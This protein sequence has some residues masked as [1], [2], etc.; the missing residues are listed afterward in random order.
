MANINNEQILSFDGY[1]V[2]VGELPDNSLAA[3]LALGFSTKI[4]NAVAGVK[5]GVLGTSKDEKARWS[6]EDISEIAAEIGLAEFSRDD[7]TANAIAAHLKGEMFESIKSGIE[8][9][10]RS[11]RPRL[12]PE[13]KLRREVAIEKLEAVFAASNA[14]LPRRSNKDERDAFETI[15]AKALSK[16]GFAA[17]VEKEFKARLK[18]RS[19][20][21]IDESE[22]A[23]L[24]G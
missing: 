19:A 14:K 10:A 12:S 7:A 9:A 3:L 2:T 17:Q 18:A 20:V 11:G 13:D 22:L 24:L 8:R 1:T 5:A 23:D 16:P 6:D 21:A 15:L 4:K